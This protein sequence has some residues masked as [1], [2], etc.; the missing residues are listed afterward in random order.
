MIMCGVVRRELLSISYQ[1][2]MNL[3][4]Y[5]CLSC[6]IMFT[7]R[8]WCVRGDHMCAI[9][10]PPCRHEHDTWMCMYR[11]FVNAQFAFPWW[12]RRTNLYLSAKC[13]HK[14]RGSPIEL[15]QHQN[16]VTTTHM[17]I[18]KRIVA[19][20]IQKTLIQRNM[21][22]ILGFDRILVE[23]WINL[24]IKNETHSEKNDAFTRPQMKVWNF[25]T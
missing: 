24:K 20:I 10:G 13:K 7:T 9:P 8:V 23:I 18:I 4:Y 5:I 19:K 17:W 15:C 2:K 6:I 21:Q 14:S 11:S 12:V 16:R 3:Y 1:F 25:N 22:K